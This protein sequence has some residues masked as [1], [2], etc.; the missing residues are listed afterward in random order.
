[1]FAIVHFEMQ[2]HRDI[3]SVGSIT[4]SV[5]LGRISGETTDTII[6]HVLPLARATFEKR[7]HGITL[8]GED[9]GPTLNPWPS[10]R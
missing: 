2:N 8:L 5:N 1:M 4:L 3:V 7:G 6:P 10:T 9:L